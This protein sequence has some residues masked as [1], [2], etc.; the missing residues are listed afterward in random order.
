MDMRVNLLLK[1]RLGLTKVNIQLLNII[2]LPIPSVS[3]FLEMGFDIN[4]IFYSSIIW[5]L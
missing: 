1:L 2:K 3:K 4:W 5:C